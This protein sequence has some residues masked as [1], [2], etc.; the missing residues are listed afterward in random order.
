[1][2]HGTPRLTTRFFAVLVVLLLFP[3]LF[4]GCDNEPTV[5]VDLNKRNALPH[6]ETQPAITY[7]YL[8]Q[9]SHS[10]SFMRHGQIVEYLRKATGLPVR[11]V[12]PD[13]F[14]SHLKM[15]ERGEIDISFS[16]PVAYLALARSGAKAFAK[17]VEPSGEPLFRGQIVVRTD[18]TEINSL[19][20]C[21]GKRWIAVD[22]LSAGG[23][24]FALGMFRDN[25]ITMQDFEE[26]AFAPGPGGKQEKALMGVYSGRYDF[27]SIREGTMDV[28][29][30][31]I[32]PGSMR[33]LA[34]TPGYPSWVYTARKGLDP[35][36]VERVSKAL[37]ALSD[38]EPEHEIIL[39]AAGIRG[40]IPAR[41][42]DYEPVRDLMNKLGLDPAKAFAE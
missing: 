22:P 29:G 18:N 35:A 14:E 25:G 39:Q 23:F 9:Y 33:V 31:N 10:T 27:A 38:N 16:N 4:G 26:V 36:I 34:T 8:P 24:L 30:R 17:V 21:K 20:D 32:E 7:A 2:E 6:T 42:K 1:M 11:Q 41:D 12:F 15:V 28:V 19:A 13:T 40:I 37:F 5:R 3:I